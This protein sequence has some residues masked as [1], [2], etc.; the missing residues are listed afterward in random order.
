M[1]CLDLLGDLEVKKIGAGEGMLV[2]NEIVAELNPDVS[3]YK[4]IHFL[5][6]KKGF[7]E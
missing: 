5:E 4:K 3:W 6:S 7:Q 2:L 1:R